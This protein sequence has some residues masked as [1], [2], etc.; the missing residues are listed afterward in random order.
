MMLPPENSFAP[1]NSWYWYRGRWANQNTGIV[2]SE[3]PCFNYAVKCLPKPPS[4]EAV[5]DSGLHIFF[6]SSNFYDN[7]ISMII[8]FSKS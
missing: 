1:S 6:S 8:S 5:W 4:G 7:D 2:F 3:D